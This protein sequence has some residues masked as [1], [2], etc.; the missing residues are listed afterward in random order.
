MLVVKI[1]LKI[2]DKEINQAIIKSFT[3]SDSRI[4]RPSNLNISLAKKSDKK[5]DDLYKVKDKIELSVCY[6]KRYPLKKIFEGL[7]KKV[8]K[9]QRGEIILECEDYSY[10]LSQKMITTTFTDMSDEDII[11]RLASTV[12]TS[13]VKKQQKYKKISFTNKSV[14]FIIKTLAENALVDYFFKG[15]K[16]FYGKKYSFN[17]QKDIYE[18]DL[19]GKYIV[20][21]NLKW[22]EGVPGL[23]VIVVGT[24]EKGKSHTG[25]AGKGSNVRQFGDYTASKDQVQ[26][27]AEKRYKELSFKGYRGTIK[28]LAEP[29]TGH[30]EQVIL[31]LDKA[32]QAWID[33]VTY[34]FSLSGG[35]RQ[36]WSIGET[37]EETDKSKTKRK[38]KL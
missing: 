17:N 1:N 33:K 10:L 9:E 4:E 36:E 34:S 35:L 13:N 25:K 21:N 24:D 7:V 22:H 18:I 15:D 14:R 29:L 3:V 2:K 20:N 37:E 23:K 27:E 32:R 26:E 28:L 8:N 19:K 12:N 31:T 11:K 30:S 16:L 5:K 38:V 6:D